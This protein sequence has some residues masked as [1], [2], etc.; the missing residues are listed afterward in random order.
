[1]SI[2]SE[3]ITC[4]APDTTRVGKE[5]YDNTSSFSK[6]FLSSTQTKQ[7]QCTPNLSTPEPFGS[8][9]QY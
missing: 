4:G 7:V 1:M 8:L 3:E 9:M 2:S 6:I 5:G